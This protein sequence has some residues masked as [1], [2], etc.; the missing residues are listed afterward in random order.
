MTAYAKL[1]KYF[2]STKLDLAQGSDAYQPFVVDA[3]HLAILTE[4]A[5][6]AIQVVVLRNQSF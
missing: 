5:T 3:F 4:A 2:I 6:V 1:E